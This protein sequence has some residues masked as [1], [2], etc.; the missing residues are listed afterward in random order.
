MELSQH[1]T[2]VFW[3]II[4]SLL[5]AL[6][7][8]MAWTVKK[9]LELDRET[10]ANQK[11]LAMISDDLGHLKRGQDQTRRAVEDLTLLVSTRLRH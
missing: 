10:T 9:V 8:T 7:S 1:L 5:F 2:G 6:G 11:V 3:T 4:S